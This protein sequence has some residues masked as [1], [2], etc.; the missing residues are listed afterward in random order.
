MN[1][2]RKDLIK[3]LFRSFLLIFFPL[4]LFAQKNWEIAKN[5]NGI[6]VY[7]KDAPGWPIKAYL[8]RGMIEKSFD[9]VATYMRQIHLRKEWV[10]DC[11]KSEVLHKVGN[12]EFIV[13]FVIE[14]PWPT[15]NRDMV[16]KIYIDKETEAGA[17]FFRFT[18]LPNYIPQIE[19]TVRVQRAIG[20]WKVRKVNETR[21][22][23]STEGRS[24]TGGTIP[25]WLANMFVEDNPYE[26]IK[27]LREILTE[28]VK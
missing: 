21:T 7:T 2:L 4:S 20:Y 25:E 6:E 10:A 13:H 22:E 14:T 19:G 24:T 26:S 9:T 11:S 17:V 5:K 1:Y 12:T 28:P 3:F 23:I 15:E 8:A 16:L 18:S 27:N